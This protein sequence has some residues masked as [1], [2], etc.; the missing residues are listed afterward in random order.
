M[1]RRDFLTAFSKA[2]LVTATVTM[3]TTTVAKSK[4][5]ADSSID[6]LANHFKTVKHKMD[7]LESNQNKMLKALVLVTAVSTGV[8]ISLIL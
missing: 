3:A 5:I 6:N 2:S 1:R 4:D 8:D 7:K